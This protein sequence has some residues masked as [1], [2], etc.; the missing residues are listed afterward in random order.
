VIVPQQTECLLHFTGLHHRALAG[1]CIRTAFSSVVQRK[2]P[3]FVSISSRFV[4]ETGQKTHRRRSLKLTYSNNHRNLS[5][6]HGELG[7]HTI[8]PDRF[9][10]A[11]Q[12]ICHNVRHHDHTPAPS[13]ATRPNNHRRPRHS[14]SNSKPLPPSAPTRDYHQRSTAPNSSTHN[15]STRY[16]ARPLQ[17]HFLAYRHISRTLH[18]SF[19]RPPQP[20]HPAVTLDRPRSSRSFAQNLGLGS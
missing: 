7:Y 10:H 17:A 19:L 11:Y 18:R 14:Y 12:P 4:P 2:H 5:S 8:G 9:S 6:K 1:V 15:K 13:S 16:S 3:T 20:S